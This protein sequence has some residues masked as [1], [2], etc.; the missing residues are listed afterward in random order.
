MSRRVIEWPLLLCLAGPLLALALAIAA[1]DLQTQSSRWQDSGRARLMQQL[2]A[3]LQHADDWAHEAALIQNLTAIE[4][5]AAWLQDHQRARV[6]QQGSALQKQS[7]LQRWLNPPRV[8]LS[9]PLDTNLD[10]VIQGPQPGLKQQRQWRQR[11]VSTLALALLAAGVATLLLYLL[12]SRRWSRLRD[13]SRTLEQGSLDTAFSSRGMS[14]QIADHLSILARRL[15]YSRQTLDHFQQDIDLRQRQRIRDLQ[16]RSQELE[17]A[18]HT[19][20][21]QNQDRSSLMSGINHELRTPLTGIIGFAELLEKTPLDAE[22]RDYVQTIRRSSADMVGLISDFLDH[23]RADAGQLT[24][25]Q[26]QLD[27]AHVVEDTIALLAPLAYKKHL[28][29]TSIVDHDVPSALLGDAARMRQILTNLVSNAIKFTDHGHVLIRLQRVDEQDTTVRLRLE[30]EDTG[31]GLNPDEQAQLFQA[32]QRFE[33]EQRPQAVGSGLGLSIVRQLSELLG[34]EVSV[35]S[36]AGRGATF[37]VVLPFQTLGGQRSKAGWEALKGRRLLVYEPH[38]IVRRSLLHQLMFWGV[39]SEHG[40][41]LHALQQQLEASLDADKP[42]LVLVGLDLPQID[43]QA[44]SALCHSAAQQDVPV[45]ALIN[46]VDSPVH[47]EL[48]QLG[49]Q[50]VLAKSVPRSHLYRVIG[51][52]IRAADADPSEP[53]DGCQLLLA[54]NNTSSQHYLKS[55]LQQSG[56]EVIVADDGDQALSLW[57]QQRPRFVLLDFNMPGLR[58]DALTRRIREIDTSG[59][60][61][62]IGMSAHLSSAQE[63]QWYGAGLDGLL[64]KPFDQAQFLRCVH[65]WLDAPLSK[66]AHTSQQAGNTPRLVDDPEL[67]QMMS[68]ELPQQLAELDQAFVAGDWESAR[69]AAHQ[70]HGT[71]AFFHLEPLK[72]HVFLLEARLNKDDAPG[73]NLRLRD[74]IITVSQD[75]KQILQSLPQPKLPD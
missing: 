72:N 12:V 55:A 37:S 17:T 65:P 22:Q 30:V 43:Q 10:L 67:A 27:P 75:V 11:V 6:W 3:Q 8:Q 57:Q 5:H 39:Q 56:A 54:E 59:N 60:T 47:N 29:L 74:D 68:E 51:E 44:L 4:H 23:Q 36:Q 52:C 38:D 73:D 25:H 20:R 26:G 69:E 31:C 58:G 62:I 41:S 24:V 18:L 64:I 70:L 48:R 35:D 14:G 46:S 71:A 66:G 34:G 2:A 49:L 45:L 63:R 53:L 13:W 61:V 21:E 28:N 50:D 9:W 40:R 32:F 33:S 15:W 19:L 1:L 16:S 42:D 7:W